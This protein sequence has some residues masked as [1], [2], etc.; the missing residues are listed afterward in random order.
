MMKGKRQILIADDEPHIIELVR[1]ILEDKYEVIAAEDGNE[2]MELLKK[3]RP[4]LILLDVMMPGINGF[5]ICE[6]LKSDP[7]T[8]DIKIAM[9]SAKVQ[10]KDIIKGLRLG[11]EYYFTKPFDPAAFETKIGE[12]LD[13]T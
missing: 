9:I 5:E 11:A 10:E 3:N 1:M 12:L 6:R 13:L 2:A 7:K 8:K 4:N